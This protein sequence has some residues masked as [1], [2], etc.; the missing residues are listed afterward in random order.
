M[1]QI[2]SFGDRMSDTKCPS[3]LT[4]QSSLKPLSY[5][6]YRLTYLKNLAAKETTRGT[7]SVLD[8]RRIDDFEEDGTVWRRKLD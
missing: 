7:P 6:L 1:H 8:R 3:F 2:H 5:L 4:Q